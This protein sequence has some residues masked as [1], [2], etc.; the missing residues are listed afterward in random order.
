MCTNYARIGYARCFSASKSFET[1]GHTRGEEEEEE[2][3]R[4]ARESMGTHACKDP[5]SR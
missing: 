5:V 2:E 4:V 3:E 1:R